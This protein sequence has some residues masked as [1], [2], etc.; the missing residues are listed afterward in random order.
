MLKAL[1]LT[2]LI[3]F[4]SPRDPA[5]GTDEATKFQL[6]AIPSRVYTALKDRSATFKA[7]PTDQSDVLLFHGNTAARDYVKYGLKGFT[8]YDNIAFKTVKE[9]IG[10][11][12]YDVVAD[13]I[14]EAMDVDT[15]RELSIEIRKLSDIEKEEIKNSEG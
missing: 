6:G 10:G 13:E 3:S 1:D 12:E 7:D 5:K 9:R 11:K 8:N 2:A 4:E 15:I 14:L